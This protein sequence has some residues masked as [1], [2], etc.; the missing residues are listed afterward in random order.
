MAD[1]GCYISPVPARLAPNYRNRV[2]GAPTI[3]R[4]H[5]FTDANGSE[6]PCDPRACRECERERSWHDYGDGAL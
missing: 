2:E 4:L 5:F 3:D 1:R 6:Q